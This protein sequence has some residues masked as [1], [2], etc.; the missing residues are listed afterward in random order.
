[1]SSSDDEGLRKPPA[2]KSVLSNEKEPTTQKSENKEMEVTLELHKTFSQAA[3]EVQEKTLSVS[4]D[5]DSVKAL[6]SFSAR[7]KKS[8]IRNAVAMRKVK[9]MNTSK[10]PRVQF[11]PYEVVRTWSKTVVQPT[12]T[13]DVEVEQVGSEQ[14][15]Q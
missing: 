10:D 1:M 9:S 5:A 8:A 4:V 13:E 14:M 15:S 3:K 11:D 7:K 6:P 2:V 12:I